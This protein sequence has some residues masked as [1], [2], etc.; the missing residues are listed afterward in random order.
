[1]SDSDT[2]SP[3]PQEVIEETS[4]NS[5]SPEKGEAGEKKVLETD[6]R[7]RDGDV[8]DD[9]HGKEEEGVVRDIIM[10]RRRKVSGVLVAV[11]TVLWVMLEIYSFNF[12]PLAS[13]TA[14]GTM[15]GM[16]VPVIYV[17]KEEQIKAYGERVRQQAT[18]LY[19]KFD[20]KVLS[21][22]KSKEEMKQKKVE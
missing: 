8:R 10:W 7:D 12:L 15:V 14:M 21:K 2:N 6:H 5:A 3:T 19:T 16:T 11:A 18:R 4:D 13:Y 20:D 9:H 22:F 17:K 1:M